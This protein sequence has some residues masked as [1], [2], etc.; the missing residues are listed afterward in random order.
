MTNYGILLHFIFH[1]VWVFSERQET[2]ATH[3]SPTSCD[4]SD[5]LEAAAP[6]SAS[7]LSLDN[8]DLSDKDLTSPTTGKLVYL[9]IKINVQ[10]IFFS[11]SSANKTME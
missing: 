2:V 11:S 1:V 5:E 6:Q 8:C 4:L 3:S 7:C 9:L 10:F